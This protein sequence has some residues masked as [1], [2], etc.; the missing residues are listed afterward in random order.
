[1][2]GYQPSQVGDGIDVSIQCN[3]GQLRV[4]VPPSLVFI[5]HSF[6]K[7]KLSACHVQSVEYVVTSFIE[8]LF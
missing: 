2:E 8:T 6:K 7:S 4:L 3:T 1:M 5:S